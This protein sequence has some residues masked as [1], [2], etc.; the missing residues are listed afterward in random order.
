MN[1]GNK[2][3]RNWPMIIASKKHVSIITTMVTSRKKVTIPKNIASGVLGRSCMED[4]RT[5]ITYQY[6][7]CENLHIADRISIMTV[8][9]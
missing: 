1:V 5:I 3:S 9:I 2:F 8:S 7:Y 6:L 4:T